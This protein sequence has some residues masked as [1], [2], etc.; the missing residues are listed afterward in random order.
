MNKPITRFGALMAEV[1]GLWNGIS[2][3]RKANCQFYLPLAPLRL[4]TK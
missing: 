4:F 3:A 1:V 2:I